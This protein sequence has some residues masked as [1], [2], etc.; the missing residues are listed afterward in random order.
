M[1]RETKAQAALRVGTLC[2]SFDA[3]RAELR[4]LEKI[5]KGEQE[6]IKA[7]A[8]G[9]YGDWIISRGSPREITDSAAVKA[10]YAEIGVE[11]PTKMSDAPVIV[12]PRIS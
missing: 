12:S 10:H 11:L 4:K 5:V 9:T 7:E 3:H 6:Q 8:P 1:P 2:A